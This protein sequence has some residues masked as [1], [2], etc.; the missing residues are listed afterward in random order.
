[1]TRPRLPRRRRSDPEAELPDARPARGRDPRPVTELL[2]DTTAARRGWAVHLEG[3]RVHGTWAEIAGEQLAAHTEPVR[4]H[5]G[6]LVVR[7]DSATWATQVRFLAAQLAQRA[8]AVLGDGQV[9]Q[10]TVVSGPL[11]GA[12]D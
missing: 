4:L 7:A 8:N 9:T 6:V 5:G 2:R 1:M 3:A 12:D 11:R 10:V